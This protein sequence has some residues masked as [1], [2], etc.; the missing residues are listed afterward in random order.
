MKDRKTE[1]EIQVQD[2]IYT[3]GE[4]SVFKNA[5]EKQKI[6][7]YMIVR[8]GHV[9]TYESLFFYLISALVISLG[10]SGFLEIQ[11]KE[12][13]FLIPIGLVMLGAVHKHSKKVKTAIHELSKLAVGVHAEKLAK[14]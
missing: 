7:R 5:L 9:N 2:L 6:T 12:L 3:Y 10:L 4:L 13:R 8:A 1:F 11:P 14:P